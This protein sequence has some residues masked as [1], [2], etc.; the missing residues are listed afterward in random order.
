M[1]INPP[2]I[3]LASQSRQRRELLETLG[4]EFEVLPADID[5]LQIDD[6]D[7]G[8]RAA[9]VALAKAKKIQAT[10]PQSIIISADTF[11]VLNGK[12]LEKPESK[13]AGRDML[14]QLSGKAVTVYTGWAYLDGYDQEVINQTSV[15]QITFRHLSQAEITKYVATYPVTHWAASFTFSHMAGIALAAEVKGSLTGVLGLPL[16]KIIP[17]LVNSGVL[18]KE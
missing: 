3:I 12:R 17:H 2:H 4:F 11:V 1:V 13:A 8:V 7:H 16:E 10:R 5:E 6:P 18:H 15:D 9:K 14:G